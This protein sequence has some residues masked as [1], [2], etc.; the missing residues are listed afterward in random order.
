MCGT[1]VFYW[2][3][4]HTKKSARSFLTYF[5]DKSKVLAHAISS[6]S[7]LLRN[8]KAFFYPDVTRAVRDDMKIWTPKRK[9]TPA[10]F[11]FNIPGLVSSLLG[12]NLCMRWRLKR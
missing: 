4:A 9:K 7:P 6:L 12:A 8:N 2:L 1:K 10:V 3:S 5:L 11:S